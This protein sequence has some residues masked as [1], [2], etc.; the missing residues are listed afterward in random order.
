[1]MRFMSEIEKGNANI[2]QQQLLS[3]NVKANQNWMGI[4]PLVMAVEQADIDIVVILLTAGA[5]ITLKPKDLGKQ[6]RNA[7]ELATE[8]RDDPKGK[9]RE[10]AAAIVKV[11]SDQKACEK[12]FEELQERLEAT[13]QRDKKRALIFITLVLPVLAAF[14]YLKFVS[15]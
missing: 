10:K 3:G 4:Y 13:R 7:L 11:L 9:F 1:M 12:H 6:G 14:L 15:K 8:M 2:V 5:D